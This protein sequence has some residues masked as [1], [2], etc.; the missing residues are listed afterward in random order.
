MPTRPSVE[1]AAEIRTGLLLATLTTVVWS[2]NTV[3]TKA[4]AGVI[5]PGSIGFTAG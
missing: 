1:T 3:V 4:A 5:S 2:V